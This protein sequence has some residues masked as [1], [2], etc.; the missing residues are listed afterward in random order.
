MSLREKCASLEIHASDEDVRR[1]LDGQMTRLPSF[2]LRNA[3]LQEEIKTEIVKAVQGMYVCPLLRLQFKQIN[4][5]LGFSLHNSIW[6]R[7]L[8]R[9][10][11]RL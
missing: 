10:P 11:L 6:I 7:W 3:D 5:S 1:Y 4:G 9:N 8:G 2:V